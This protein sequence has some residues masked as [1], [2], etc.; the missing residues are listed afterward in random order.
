MNNNNN[1]NKKNKNNYYYTNSLSL[2][3]E[4]NDCIIL[5]ISKLTLIVCYQMSSYS[6]C[7]GA[8]AR[9]RACVCFEEGVKFCTVELQQSYYCPALV[10][11]KLYLPTMPLIQFSHLYTKNHRRK[12][13]NITDH[14]RVLRQRGYPRYS[15]RLLSYI[16]HTSVYVYMYY[17]SIFQLTCTHEYGYIQ[18]Y[19]E[20]M[21]NQV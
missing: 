13:Y 2:L 14:M 18:K 19:S 15:V 5:Q 17:E 11:A 12:T 6:L 1:N 16:I 21:Y 8:R 20:R 3:I 10:L 9:A 7:V 4:L